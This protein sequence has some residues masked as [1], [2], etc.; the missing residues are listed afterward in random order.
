M[1]GNDFEIEQESFDGGIR[2]ILH[3]RI[4]SVNYMIL[5]D[6][7]NETLH[8]GHRN[9]ILNMLRVDHLSSAGIKVLLKAYKDAQKFGGKLGIEGPSENVRNVLGMT[10]LDTLLIK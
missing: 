4:N 3:G 5:E 2:F 8:E 6:K 1:R 10:A 7:L 9:I